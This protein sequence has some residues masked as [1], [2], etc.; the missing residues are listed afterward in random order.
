MFEQFKTRSYELE[1]LDTG[2]YTPAEYR[3]W[4]KEMFFIHRFFGEIRA[5]RHSLAQ[6]ICDS[7]SKR[8]S[9]LDVGAGSGELLSQLAKTTLDIE[10]YFVGLEID[11]MAAKSIKARSIDAVQ[12]DALMLPFGDSSFDHSFCTL[13]LHHL[14]DENAVQ[15]LREM[16][17]VARK[18]IYCIDLN[19]D[20]TSY[21]TYKILGRI[22]LQ[23]FT[24]E[25]GALSILRSFTIDEMAEL[26][27]DAGLTDIKVE[28]SRLN[29][30]ILSARKK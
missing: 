9:V 30:L 22:F 15:L 3:R 25:D 26:A 23:K 20:P 10:T 24:L 21:Y 14:S 8:G 17:R 5:L 18:R 13:F 1:R 29:R 19:R 6:D 2:D 11:G 12:A 7:G 16:A 28:R 27:M 4:E